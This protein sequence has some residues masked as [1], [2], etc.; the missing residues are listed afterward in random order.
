MTTI[1]ITLKYLNII[2]ALGCVN[3]YPFITINKTKWTRVFNK[4]LSFPNLNTKQI[5]LGTAMIIYR[6]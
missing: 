4:R 6:H 3:H 5:A 1:D 2:T